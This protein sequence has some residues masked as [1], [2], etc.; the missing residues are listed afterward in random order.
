MI[1]RNDGPV[2]VKASI[3]D[4]LSHIGYKAVSSQDVEILHITRDRYEILVSALQAMTSFSDPTTRAF[5]QDTLNRMY[6]PDRATPFEDLR[7]VIQDLKDDNKELRESLAA[8]LDTMPNSS[9]IQAAE[10]AKECLK[11]PR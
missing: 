2:G 5:S 7:K 8:V 1:G 6:G 3:R 4:A 10:K 9:V 11:K